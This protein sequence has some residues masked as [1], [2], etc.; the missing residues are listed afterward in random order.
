MFLRVQFLE[1]QERRKLFDVL[2][3]KFVYVNSKRQ[4]CYINGNDSEKMS[5]ATCF[6]WFVWQKGFVGEPKIRWI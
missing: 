3:P 4:T 1:G 2:P 5:G 6:C